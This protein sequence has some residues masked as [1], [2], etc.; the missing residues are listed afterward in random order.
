VLVGDAC[1]G[2]EPRALA[3]REN[4]PLHAGVVD[5]STARGIVLT[6]EQRFR[7]SAALGVDG[8]DEHEDRQEPER[9]DEE[10]HERHPRTQLFAPGVA[11]V[12]KGSK[13]ALEYDAGVSEHDRE[14]LVQP[15]PEVLEGEDDLPRQPAPP[16]DPYTP[17]PGPG[18]GERRAFGVM[19]WAWLAVLVLAAIILIVALR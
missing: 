9:G 1:E 7:T 11:S 16:V 6:R 13:R 15:E 2:M 8:Q 12:R 10:T 19:R 14:R 5:E 17:E 4:D 18:P 3:A